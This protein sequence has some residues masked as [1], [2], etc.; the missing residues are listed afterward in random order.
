[1]LV[2]V[3][4]FC[5][6]FLWSLFFSNFFG[7]GTHGLTGSSPS[8]HISFS[9]WVTAQTAGVLYV[10]SGIGVYT[11]QGSD[12]QHSYL[13][14]L[15]GGS[16]DICAKLYRYL[17]QTF[18]LLGSVLMIPL[19]HLLLLLLYWNW[20]IPMYYGFGMHRICWNGSHSCQGPACPG[21]NNARD[22]L[23]EFKNWQ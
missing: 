15:S 19:V 12:R 11:E 8:V 10:W 18:D 4:V 7:E 3:M 13:D 1:M 22:S 16:V 2:I 6:L 14:A 20:T 21:C 5:D 17:Y 9:F 23:W